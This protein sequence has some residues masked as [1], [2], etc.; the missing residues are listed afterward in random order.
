[1]ALA[2]STL[3]A[4]SRQV[5]ELRQDVHRWRDVMEAIGGLGVAV[6]REPLSSLVSE[7]RRYRRA[8]ARCQSASRI[9]LHGSEERLRDS[10]RLIFDAH[11]ASIRAA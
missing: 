8:S 3:A 5:A 10:R 1:M 2:R 6:P 11:R 7:R 9:L 4:M